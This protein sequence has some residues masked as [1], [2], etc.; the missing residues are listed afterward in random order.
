MEVEDLIG[1]FVNTLVLRSD[2]SG[3]PS[4]R[5]FLRRVRETALEA[6]VQQDLPFEKLVEELKTERSLSYSPLF[7]VMFA[8]QNAPSGTLDLSD[9]TLTINE[10]DT[11]TSKFDLTLFIDETEQG[12]RALIEYN[13]DLYNR[14]TIRR[15]LGHYQTLLESITKKPDSSISTLPILTK[16]EQDQ[17]LLEWNDTKTDYPQN[18][19]IHQIFEAQVEKTPDA[20]AVVYEDDQMSYRALNERSN[21][22]AH[23]L[24]KQGVGPDI[25]VGICMDRCPETVVGILGILKAGGAYVPMDPSYPAERLTFM[26]TDAQVPIILTKK[27][28]L[29]GIPHHGAKIVYLSDDEIIR[30][31]AKENPLTTATS[32]DLVYVIYTSGST[33]QPK[34]VA[35]NHHVLSN[36]ITWQLKNTTLSEGAS[37]L[38]F[39]SLSFDVSFQEIFTSL[40]SGGSLIMIPESIRKDMENVATFIANK[41]IDRL[42]LPFVALQQLAEVIQR[43]NLCINLREVSTAGEQLQITPAICELFSQLKKCS[44]YNQYGPS[45]S[46]VVTE[47]TLGDSPE[48][49]SYLPPIGHPIDNTTVY[50]T[51]S[52]LQP[53]PIGVTGELLIGVVGHGRGYLNL[54]EMTKEKFVSNPFSNDLKDRLY[55]TGDLV[56]YLPDGNIEF[57]GRIDNQVKIRGFRIE[58]GEI[59]VNLA[60]CPGVNQVVVLAREDEPGNKRLVAYIVPEMSSKPS[61]SELREFLKKQLPEYMT[62]SVFMMLDSLPLTPNGKVDRKELP[63]PDQKRPELDKEF[64]APST[65]TEIK[66]A[67]I[68][69]RLLKLKEVGIHDNFFGLGGHSLLATQLISSIGDTFQVD[70]PLR[71]IFETPTVCDLAESVTTALQSNS[72]LQAPPLKPVRRQEKMSLSFAQQRLWF[73]DQLEQESSFYNISS[74]FRLTGALDVPVLHRSLNSIVS[75][76]EI[77]RT[78]FE[79]EE[80][81]P[82]QVIKPNIEIDLPVIDLTK[83]DESKQE[84]EM[85]RLAVEEVQKPFKLSKGPLIRCTL[86]HLDDSN[87]VLLLTMH[88]I[89]SDGWS[90]GILK[91]ELSTLYTAFLTGKSSSLDELSIQYGDF[92]SWQRQWLQGEVLGKQLS[93]W[94]KRLEGAPSLLELPTDLPRPAVQSYQGARES[95]ILPSELSEAIQSLSRIEG[96]TPFMTMLAAFQVLLYRYTGVEDI[97]V[98]TPIANRTRM[99]IENLIGFFVNTLVLRS[100]LSGN[101]SFREFLHRVR[102]VALEAYAHQDLPFE[103]LV[104]EM[105]PERSLSYSPLFQVMFAYQNFPSESLEMPDLTLTPIKVDPK[106]SKFDLSLFVNETEQGLK[107]LMEYNTD[108]FNRDTIRRM[109]GHFKTLLES[110]TND[111]DSSISRLPLLTKAEQNQLLLEWNNTITDY[112]QNK[113]IHQIFESQ[114]KKTPNAVAVIYDDLQLT[115]KELNDRSSQL[116]YYL[117]ECGVGP[118]IL[119]GICMERSI[120]MV[121]GL[122]GIFKAGGAYMP[123]DPAYPRERIAFMLVD[124]QASVLLTQEALIAELPENKAL[125]VCLDRDWET[126]SQCTRENPVATTKEENLAYVIYTSGS[127]GKPKGVQIS[128]RALANLLSSMQQEPG[129][130]KDDVL[131]SV[132]TLSFDIAALELY[133]P[134]ITGARV[135]VVS[136]EVAFDG[137]QLLKAIAGS[138]A[139]VMQATPATWSLLLEAGWKGSS[140]LKALCGG[141]ALPLDLA[142]QLVKRVSSLWNL[143]GPTETTIWS[144]IYKVEPGTD[145]V[146]IGYPIANT[147][148][149]ILDFHL[150]PVPIGV[151]GELYIGGHC[152][153]RNYLNRPELTAEK[154]IPNPF[155]EE[156]DARLYKTGD[157]ACYLP[158]GAINFLGR[159]DNQVK[160]R[161]FRIEL[162]EVE[163]NLAKHPAVKQVVAM[164]RED[165]PGNKRIVAYVV[166]E[167]VFKPSTSGLRDFLKK[168][169]PEHM[170]PLVFIMLE[171]MPLTPNG[172]VDRKALPAPD[173]KRPELEKVFAAPGTPTEIKLA[174]IWGRLLNLKEVGVN[175]D[176]FEL[177][178]HSLLCTQLISRIRDAFH[179][180]L[181]LRIVFESPFLAE[182]AQEIEQIKANV[183]EDKEMG[184]LLDELEELSDEEVQQ[185]L[186]GKSLNTS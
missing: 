131:L 64:V 88:H 119:V 99:E 52:N 22:L 58:L 142:N 35:L 71:K 152:L 167:K 148:I 93:F 12:L 138:G 145:I 168:K 69:C 104:E 174:E 161:G 143:Y 151:S 153:A 83:F 67:E 96:G 4:F 6:Y 40:C 66:L 74:F 26:M 172:K 48:N 162:G 44:F 37:T 126:I 98:G 106:I 23:Y 61:T 158:D 173:Q 34:G 7:Q 27:S 180:D 42:F 78:T 170:I 128:H 107:A 129:L 166:P 1:F 184:L 160:I 103:K 18:K 13:T 28:L 112:P 169:L 77:L 84:P 125:V 97:L 136:H 9:L 86:L 73:L 185:R 55:K 15:M 155:S 63:T 53:V 79:S 46:H 183:G 56:R 146:P 68:W 47:Y 111:P 87:H 101:P 133:L 24:R 95:L 14:D 59:E 25:P 30:E 165:E 118:D 75:R 176:F 149:Y 92:A 39:T 65:P 90:M 81:P 89:I 41:N 186:N 115:Y 150:Q 140:Q 49:W 31:K 110:I 109:L 54:P 175:D 72:Y 16:R 120:E 134:L 5:E 177:G 10:V 70:I 29:D 2:L 62:P 178:G 139:T 43:G 132:T 19:C 113:C 141:E 76:H 91:K 85:R 100:D 116:A 137:T 102:E 3:N 45:E 135:V 123:L 121:V 130:T 8:F 50:I 182:I 17:M 20:V 144:A 163:A 60:K 36:L 164:A 171:S 80:G 156:L 82:F 117:R 108:L 127:T 181:P 33:G 51:D 179:V 157:L 21:Q 105:Q 57:L 147:Q 159:I 114:S 124:S 154:F 38:Q 94:K 122:L 32:D 11:R